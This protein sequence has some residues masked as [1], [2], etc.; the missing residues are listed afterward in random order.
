ME[1]NKIIK[2]L[3][4]ELEIIKKT[5]KETTLEIEILGVKSKLSNKARRGT[6]YSSKVKI[7]QDEFSVQIR[8]HR[9]EHQQ[10]NAKDGSE[11]VRCRR[12]HRK[13]GHNNQRKF[14]MQK[15]LTQN[16]QEI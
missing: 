14:K 12:F 6:S 9:C 15:D 13:Y 3:K 8:N 10:Q 16:I 2:D 1:Y 7:F 4:R 5:Q 11:N